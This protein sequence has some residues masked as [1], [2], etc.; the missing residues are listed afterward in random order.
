MSDSFRDLTIKR[1]KDNQILKE[2]PRALVL[3]V[4]FG[5]CFSRIMNWSQLIERLRRENL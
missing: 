5:Q 2:F 1:N 4:Y 3:E